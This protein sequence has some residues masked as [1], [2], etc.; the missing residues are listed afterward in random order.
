M[1]KSHTVIEE[2]GK[3]HYHQQSFTEI[4]ESILFFID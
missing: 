2:R 1:D 4:S 3:I